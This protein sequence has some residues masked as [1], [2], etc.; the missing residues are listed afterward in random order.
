M[1]RSCLGFVYFRYVGSGS[2]E[3]IEECIL[4]CSWILRLSLNGS[5]RVTRIL[6]FVRNG[7][8]RSLKWVGVER[9]DYS[10][11]FWSYR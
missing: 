9:T 1:E 11:E 5:F 10:L 2:L 8:R 3:V 6:T 4:G 7:N